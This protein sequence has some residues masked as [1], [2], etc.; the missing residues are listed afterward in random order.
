VS[1]HDSIFHA[2]KVLQGA[3]QAR[4]QFLPCQYL[5]SSAKSGGSY[6]AHNQEPVLDQVRSASIE[7][8]AEIEIER[9]GREDVTNQL[10]RDVFALHPWEL[11]TFEY[12]SKI[13]VLLDKF[14]ALDLKIS[15]RKFRLK[16]YIPELHINF[17]PLCRFAE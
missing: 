2:Q 14:G 10:V 1:W 16:K 7:Q 4:G 3:R 12:L 11:A 15:L 8:R 17:G 9:V 6:G 5:A 13:S